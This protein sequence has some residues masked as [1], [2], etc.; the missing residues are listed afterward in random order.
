MRKWAAKSQSCPANT[1]FRFFFFFF[2][3]FS[4]FFPLSQ[5]GRFESPSCFL[6]LFSQGPIRWHGGLRFRV[7]VGACFGVALWTYSK[8]SIHSLWRA[9]D[10]FS[11][12]AHVRV[13][14]LFFA[15][16]FKLLSRDAKRITI[17]LWVPPIL[18]LAHTHTHNQGPV[19]GNVKPSRKFEWQEFDFGDPRECCPGFKSLRSP[20]TTSF[21]VCRC[22]S[23][24]L[25]ATPGVL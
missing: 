23:P 6:F 12:V 20:Q 10:P 19:E 21:L 2:P 8:Q 24:G 11:V 25:L 17:I 15:S 9:S 5:P 3:F 7:F 4:F 18:T 22:S 14:L 1:K 13:F 16:L